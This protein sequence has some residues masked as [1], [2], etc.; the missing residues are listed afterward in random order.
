ML[1]DFVEETNVVQIYN[2]NPD[3]WNTLTFCSESLSASNWSVYNTDYSGR[4]GCSY[5]QIGLG[6]PLLCLYWFIMIK[7]VKTR[8]KVALNSNVV[9]SSLI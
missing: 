9:K 2:I 1:L 5:L 4:R 7:I 8:Q 6:K 3:I